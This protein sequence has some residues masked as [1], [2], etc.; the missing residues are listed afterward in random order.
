MIASSLDRNVIGADLAIVD[1]E[2]LKEI[3]YLF[4]INDELVFSILCLLDTLLLVDTRLFL[5]SAVLVFANIDCYLS[6]ESS[7]FFLLSI[8][9][10]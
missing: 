6:D 4:C 1:I 10:I 5:F 9:F 7:I 3:K 8:D 2:V